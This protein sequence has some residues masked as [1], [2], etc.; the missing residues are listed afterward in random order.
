VDSRDSK[1]NE[2]FD[3]DRAL[4]EWLDKEAAAAG[5]DPEDPYG[6]EL[7]IIQRWQSNP[8]PEDFNFLYNRHQPLIHA[9]GR[10]YIQSTT[11]PKAAVKSN[12]LKNYVTALETFDPSRGRQFSSHVYQWMGRTGRYL[13]RYSNVGRIPEDRSWLIDT[14]LTRERAL[15]DM[16]GRPPSDTELADDVL[17]AADDV[18]DLKTRK[19]SPKMV[20]TLR[21]EL[22]KDY[23]AEAPGGEAVYGE[24]SDLRRQVVFLHGSLNPEQQVVLE[25]TFEGFGKPTIEDPI[26]LANQIGMSPQKVRAIRKQIQNK[27]RRRWESKMG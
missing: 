11:L 5:L 9:A 10:R 8:N 15:E 19:I 13:Q 18:A 12:M 23:L 26:E 25:H 27:V 16:L 14:L 21:K 1:K 6:D 7:E 24:D 2:P 3:V 20:A 17:L 4:D 22:R